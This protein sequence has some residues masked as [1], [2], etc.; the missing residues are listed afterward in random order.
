M[1]EEGGEVADKVGPLKPAQ[2]GPLHNQPRIGVPDTP[3]TLLTGAAGHIGNGAQTL[4]S[5][6]TLPIAPGRT[7]S[8]L[9]LHN[10]NRNARSHR[11]DIMAGSVSRRK[12][13]L[14]RKLR[15]SLKMT[16]ILQKFQKSNWK[17]FWM[18]MTKKC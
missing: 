14:T 18:K 5:V 6:A 12:K 4:I 8:F 10:R 2:M 13:D 15:I 17:K 3:I 7:G 11:F 16:K 9:D 1:P